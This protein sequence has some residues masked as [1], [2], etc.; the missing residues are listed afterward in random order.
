MV[1]KSNKFFIITNYLSNNDLRWE[2]RNSFLFT[3]FIESKPIFF[4]I[5]K[6]SF[7]DIRN[8][9]QIFFFKLLKSLLQE[10]I[11]INS[12]LN[13]F[14]LLSEMHQCSCGKLLLFKQLLMKVRLKPINKSGSLIIK[15]WKI[16][17]KSCDNFIFFHQG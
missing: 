2:M 1:I 11:M 15:R 3:I 7:F 5:Q 12:L 10:I 13:W 4:K 8:F 6:F 9:F 16:I 17:Y 14:Q